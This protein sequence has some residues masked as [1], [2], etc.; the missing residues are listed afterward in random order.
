MRHWL[1]PVVLRVAGRPTIEDLED[2]VL[3]QEGGGNASITPAVRIDHAL[4]VVTL[5]VL[6]GRATPAA[7]AHRDQ[8]GPHRS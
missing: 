7:P 8:K 3:G 6:A 2:Q 4:M 5:F 1:A